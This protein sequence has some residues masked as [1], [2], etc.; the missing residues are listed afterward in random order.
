MRLEG[1]P[2]CVFSETDVGMLALGELL[3]LSMLYTHGRRSREQR[4]QLG[5]WPEHRSWGSH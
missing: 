2:T 5:F 3:A 1:T 4:W